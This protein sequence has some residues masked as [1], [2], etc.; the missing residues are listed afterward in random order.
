MGFCST[1]C[2]SRMY[3]PRGVLNQMQLTISSKLLRVSAPEYR[4]QGVYC[5]A[6][7][8]TLHTLRLDEISSDVSRSRQMF[9]CTLRSGCKQ[10]VQLVPGAKFGYH[11]GVIL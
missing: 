5:T 7:H 11:N 6:R 2:T 8:D 4:S 9:V 1:E 10:P 3:Q